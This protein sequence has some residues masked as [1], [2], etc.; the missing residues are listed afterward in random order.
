MKTARSSS[1]VNNVSGS[2][3]YCTSTARIV[4]GAISS[5]AGVL[6]L[7]AC[8]GRGWISPKQNITS[9][10]TITLRND[11]NVSKR[12]Y[13]MAFDCIN[14][15]RKQFGKRCMPSSGL[16]AR[17][18]YDFFGDIFQGQDKIDTPTFNCAIGHVWLFRCTRL[19]RDGN[20]ANFPD[21]AQRRRPVTI[22]A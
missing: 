14:P 9:R 19:L 12:E 17:N 18:P 1:L 21:A 10:H 2:T 16:N 3:K 13:E 7:L 6:L 15:P 20:A 11:T 22:E 4:S 8:T 5:T